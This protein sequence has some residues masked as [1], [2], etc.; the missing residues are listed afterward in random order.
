[1][2]MFTKRENPEGVYVKVVQIRDY[3]RLK[4]KN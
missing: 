3:T 2:D 1:M 4:A